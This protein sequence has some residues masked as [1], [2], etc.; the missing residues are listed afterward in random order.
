[1][2]KTVIEPDVDLDYLDGEVEVETATGSHALS[3]AECPRSLFFRDLPTAVSVY[4]EVL[5]RHGRTP[6]LLPE[7]LTGWAAGDVDLP[8]TDLLA[9][10]AR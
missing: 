3:T 6:G 9:D 8:V 10:L 5:G 4:T 1:M 7:A 2:D